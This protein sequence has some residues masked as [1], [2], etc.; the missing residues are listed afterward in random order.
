[1]TTMAG[2]S[3]CESS[4]GTERLSRGVARSPGLGAEGINSHLPLLVWCVRE[5][6]RSSGG[7]AWTLR[8]MPAEMCLVNTGERGENL[9]GSVMETA[10][11]HRRRERPLL[12]VNCSWRGSRGT[13]RLGRDTEQY[14][15]W[16]SFM[17][18]PLC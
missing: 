10:A 12:L 7:E 11:G 1:M 5:C 18:L 13:L 9:G 16:A 4:V 17:T 15:L 6:K 8:H 3:R 14:T 2:S